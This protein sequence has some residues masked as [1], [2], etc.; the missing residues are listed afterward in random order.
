MKSSVQLIDTSIGQL[1]SNLDMKSKSHESD[2]D[3]IISTNKKIQEA[4]S[5]SRQDVGRTKRMIMDMEENMSALSQY[6]EFQQPTNPMR[7]KKAHSVAD[8]SNS[9]PD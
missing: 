5:D 2:M 3:Q 6:D 4:V 8:T 9:S 1:K 7:N